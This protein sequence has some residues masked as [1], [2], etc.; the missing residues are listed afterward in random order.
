MFVHLIQS[1]ISFLCLLSLT[2]CVLLVRLKDIPSF[3]GVYL[4][5]LELEHVGQD[6]SMPYFSCSLRKENIR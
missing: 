4:V 3:I 2:R 1:R 5:V 6:I